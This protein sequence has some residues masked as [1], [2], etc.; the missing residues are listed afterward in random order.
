M[1]K[2]SMTKGVIVEEGYDTEKYIDVAKLHLLQTMLGH[3][4][5]HIDINVIDDGDI[6]SLIGTIYVSKTNPKMEES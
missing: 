3:I 1:T 4:S 5:K 2:I 6:I